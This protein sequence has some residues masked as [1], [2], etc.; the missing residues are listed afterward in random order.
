ML[1][2]SRKFPISLYD[3][4]PYY[5][6]LYPLSIDFQQACNKLYV[7]L[8]SCAHVRTFMDFASLG[9]LLFLVS[10]EIPERSQIQCTVIIDTGR[11]TNLNIEDESFLSLND[12]NS[13]P[14]CTFGHIFFK[15]DF[16]IHFQYFVAQWPDFSLTFLVVNKILLLS[17]DEIS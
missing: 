10:L 16:G 7:I 12:S 4:D 6:L 1:K 15:F 13:P 3:Q 17:E 8:N 5:G 9:Y 11:L 14:R 2:M